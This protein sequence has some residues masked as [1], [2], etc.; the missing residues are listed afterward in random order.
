MPYGVQGELAV[1]GGGIA[2]GYLN[3][4]RLTAD[5]FV[6]DPVRRRGT[7]YLTGDLVRWRTDG[8]LEFLGRI[9]QQIKIRGYRIE[10]G[11]VERQLLKHEDVSGA[12][13]N[14]YRDNGTGFY[15]CAFISSGKKL[16]ASQLRE[17]LKEKVP[18]YMVPA[19]FAFVDSI[20]LTAGGKPNRRALPAPKAIRS[21]GYQPPVG[22]LETGLTE[23]FAEVLEMECGSVGIYD[24]FFDLGGHSIKATILSSRI[25]KTF[26]VKI[27]IG[28]FFKGPTVKEL[29]KFIQ[30][31][32]QSRYDTIEPVEKKDYYS[33]SSAQKRLW[34][35]DQFSEEQG[36]YKIALSYSLE[37]LDVECF[38]EAFHSLVRRHE[39]LRTTFVEVEGE[40]RQRVHTFEDSDLQIEIVDF[41]NEADG[42]ELAASLAQKDYGIDFDLTAG[43]LARAKL[44]RLSQK[45]FLFFLTLHHIIADAWSVDVLQKELMQIYEAAVMGGGA[46]LKEL[47]IQY[48]DYSDWQNSRIGQGVFRHHQQFWMSQFE[49]GVPVLDLQTDFPR[50]KVKGINGDNVMVVLDRELGQA[51]RSLCKKY[52]CSLFM[53]MLSTIAILL[54]YYSGQEDLVI[55]SP[56]AGRD[57]GDLEEQIGFYLNMLPLRISFLDSDSFAS[58]LGDVKQSAIKAFQHQAYPFDLLINDLKLIRDSSRSP[59]FDVLVQ[60]LNTASGVQENDSDI[61]G[62]EARDRSFQV[63]LKQS[64]YDLVFNFSEMGGYITLYL[65]YNIDLFK[66]ETVELMVKRFEMLLRIVTGDE[67]ICIKD[68]HLEEEYSVP[69]IQPAGR[70]SE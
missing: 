42:K 69:M 70:R 36:A 41:S 30:D 5:K 62:E 26:G 64:K 37:D 29:A 67:K 28:V 16:Q 32:E 66:R 47:D 21:E 38:K 23:L 20:P 46:P 33:L 6:Q 14:A 25:H 35:I 58:L 50:P 24:N 12:V 9:D 15:L 55:G 34:V 56:I 11:E 7:V 4:P 45:R 39:I 2:R 63:E 8:Q 10:L 18:H 51:V 59:L 61:S 44:V 49:S 1:A 65:E 48:K 57:H 60:V 13:V 54:Y 17:Y 43:P 52:N 19:R 40:P 53:T 27:P 31:S 22:P 68:I 3:R